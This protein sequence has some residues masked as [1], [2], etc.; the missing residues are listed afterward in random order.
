VRDVREEGGRIAELV[1][2]RGRVRATMKELKQQQE[3]ANC[4]GYPV[5]LVFLSAVPYRA[6]RIF[7]L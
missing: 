1:V 4:S 6:E 5:G 3:C 7:Y 2:G